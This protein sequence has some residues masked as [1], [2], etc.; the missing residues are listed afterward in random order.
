MAFELGSHAE[1]QT[2]LEQL[3]KTLLPLASLSYQ[4]IGY[5]M[6]CTSLN[7]SIAMA[8]PCSLQTMLGQAKAWYRVAQTTTLLGGG[9]KGGKERHIVLIE[10]RLLSPIVAL[11]ATSFM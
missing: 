2:S 1:A 4:I 11:V 9:G 7:T 10:L 5:S 3:W 8:L 6:L